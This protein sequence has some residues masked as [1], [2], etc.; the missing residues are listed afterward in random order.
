MRSDRAALSDQRTARRIVV[1][2]FVGPD[3]EGKESFETALDWAL[4]HH[5]L[6]KGESYRV[7]SDEVAREALN[8]GEGL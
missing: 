1:E 6:E 8:G 5:V 7:V 2:F 4:C 3:P